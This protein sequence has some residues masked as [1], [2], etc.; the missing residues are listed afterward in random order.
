MIN[1]KRE[2]N[3]KRY[4]GMVGLITPALLVAGC[5]IAS[6]SVKAAE[7]GN[8]PKITALLA[9]AKA[10]AV[11]LKDDSTDM[12]SFTRSSLSWE[13][14]AHKVEMIKGH[15]NKTGKLLAKLQAEESNGSAWQQTAIRRIEPLL[16]ELAANT[17]KTINYLNENKTKIHFTDF[18][19][20]VQMNCE[21]ATD[22]EE[23]VRD[24][25]NYG[26]AKQKL[27]RLAEK[28]EITG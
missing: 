10:E 4:R 22:L 18:K 25:V 13:S 26:E 27:E 28:L 2:V 1:I 6:T 3:M 14:Y 20:Y 9:E 23:L 24:F 15:V 7:A 19:D 5:F 17:E 16:K 21:L 8:S 12:E 11:E